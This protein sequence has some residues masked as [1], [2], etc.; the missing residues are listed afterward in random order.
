MIAEPCCW[1]SACGNSILKAAKASLTLLSS[2]LE[3][4]DW[5]NTE[6]FLWESV[7]S[8]PMFGVTLSIPTFTNRCAM[9]LDSAHQ[10]V[11]IDD[12]KGCWRFG[13]T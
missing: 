2:Y 13:P 9:R 10:S 8:Q 5:V 11:P 1:D 7:Q 6:R 3:L 4:F 12:R